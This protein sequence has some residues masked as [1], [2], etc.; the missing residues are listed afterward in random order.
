MNQRLPDTCTLPR[1]IR[2]QSQNHALV[3]V[4]SAWVVATDAFTPS[5]AVTCLTLCLSLEPLRLSLLLS[6]NIASCILELLCRF[7][8]EFQGVAGC[9]WGVRLGEVIEAEVRARGKS[10]QR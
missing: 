10:A 2:V 1:S 5:I 3:D 6:L 4:S 8:V 9:D 7:G